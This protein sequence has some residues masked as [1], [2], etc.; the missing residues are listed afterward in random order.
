MKC[1]W[2]LL[3]L[4]M[5]LQ[6]SLVVFWFILW[7]VSNKEGKCQPLSKEW[8]AWCKVMFEHQEDA[9]NWFVNA[10]KCEQVWWS[11]KKYGMWM[12]QS[13][14]IE[15]TLTIR[16]NDSSTTVYLPV[17]TPVPNH[18]VWATSGALGHVQRSMSHLEAH[19]SRVNIYE[20]TGTW[21]WFFLEERHQSSLTY[22]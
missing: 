3:I 8:P 1:L 20:Y 18:P 10:P 4:S 13:C 17:Q 21:G 15:K 9:V 5:I 2:L 7:K 11:V 14:H 22:S 6:S 12:W 19:L 16:G